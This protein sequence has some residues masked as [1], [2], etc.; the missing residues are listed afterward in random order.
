MSIKRTN[1]ETRRAKYATISTVKKCKECFSVSD[2]NRK[3]VSNEKVLFQIWNLPCIITCPFA[4][5][6]CKESCYAVKAETNPQRAKVVNASRG[7]NYA[8]SQSDDFVPMMIDYIKIKL[9]N[10]SD[11]RKIV[12]RIHESGDF[13][14]EEYANKW[15]EISDFFKGDNR[16]TF[17]AYTKSIRF[18]YGKKHN[19]NLRFSLWD[20][21]KAEEIELAKEMRLPVYTAVKTF[22]DS[23]NYGGDKYDKY[24]RCRCTDCGTCLACYTDKVKM[25]ACEI[26]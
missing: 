14:S 16:I 5:E 7:R 22:T 4:T 6:H 25:I 11:D 13:Y 10:L 23:V 18:F 20:D 1:R 3:L 9:N 15:I 24:F 19:I 12:F 21:T 26:H 17:I 2:G 8:F